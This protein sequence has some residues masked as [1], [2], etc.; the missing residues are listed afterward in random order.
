MILDRFENEAL[1]VSVSPED[2]ATVEACA[3]L[4]ERAIAS[5]AVEPMGGAAL[6]AMSPHVLALVGRGLALFGQ[7]VLLIDV[8]PMRGLTLTPASSWDVSG[9]PLEA[10]WTYRLD[11]IG[12]SGSFT[13]T[14][15]GAAVLHFRIGADARAPWRGRPPLR[16][17]QATANLAAS[18]EAQLTQESKLPT[19]RIVPLSGT[20]EQVK[21]VG[22]M[23]ARGGITVTGLGQ[24]APGAEQVPSSRYAPQR[25]GPS[26]EAAYEELRQHV[27]QDIAAAFGISPS[28]FS[29][30][31]DG[32]GQRE[33]W[34]RFWAGTI[35]PIGSLLEAEIRAKLAPEAS[36]SFPALRASDEDGRS[37]AV[38]RRA[39]ALKTLLEA[40][41]ERD[42]ALR[43]AGLSE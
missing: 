1:G 25:I 14:R 8:D 30:A 41:V 32:S 36:V 33:A 24:S 17:S 16:R 39:R 40:G 31:G 10:E 2:L 11:M 28:L 12:P 37:R 19:G 7:S 3:G 29:P 23:I 34:R 4:W 9:S 22:S 27:G 5:A 15:P 18:I 38:D 21:K 6:G 13:V 26:P 35:A 20:A 43:L 42:T